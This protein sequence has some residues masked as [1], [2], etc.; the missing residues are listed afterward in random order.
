MS[1]T[2]DVDNSIKISCLCQRRRGTVD[3]MGRDLF[4]RPSRR[5]IQKIMLHPNHLMVAAVQRLREW[6]R[7]GGRFDRPLWSSKQQLPL[8]PVEDWHP[9]N[10]VQRKLNVSAVSEVG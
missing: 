9:E 5:D 3:I 8:P 7:R 1:W 2:A 4:Q 6:T 10:Q